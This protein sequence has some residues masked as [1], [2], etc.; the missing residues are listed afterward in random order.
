MENNNNNKN[1]I[2]GLDISTTTIGIAL[3]EINN[4]NNNDNLKLKLL[5]HVSPKVIQQKNISKTE[6]LFIKVNI[7]KENFL[8]KYKDILLD[9]KVIVI[10]EPLLLSNNIYTC[11]TLLKFNG[12]ISK[13]LYDEFNIV[14]NYISSYDSRKYAFP[15]LMSIRKINKK[16]IELSIKELKNKQPVLFGAYAH[17]VEKKKIIW[18]KVNDKFNKDIQWLYNKKNELIKENYDIADAACCILGYLNQ[19]KSIT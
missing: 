5:H 1:L 10:E 13:M 18:Q 9:V 3:M 8:E 2:L 11:A 16:G 7:F 4:D 19:L 14:C 15:E 17:D 12:M 6:E